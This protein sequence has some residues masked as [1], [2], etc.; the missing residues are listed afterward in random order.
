MSP[1]I[2]KRLLS[3]VTVEQQHCC[4]PLRTLISTGILAASAMHVWKH[5]KAVL[6]PQPRI[7]HEWSH[8]LFI[9]LATKD[10]CASKRAIAYVLVWLV[11]LGFF[12]Y[13]FAMCLLHSPILNFQMQ[14]PQQV[15][16]LPLTGNTSTACFEYCQIG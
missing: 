16:K 7:Y 14:S 1:Q 10:K 3:S 9:I 5:L 11:C 12:N 2:G 13:S 8:I 4:G 15:G 6:L